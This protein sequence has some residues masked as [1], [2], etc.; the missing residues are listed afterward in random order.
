MAVPEF[1]VSARVHLVP[2]Q[3]VATLGARSDEF[4]PCR[5]LL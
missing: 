1:S 5:V 4:A 3:E 2:Q